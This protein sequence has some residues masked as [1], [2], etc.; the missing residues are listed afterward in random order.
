[1]PV[2]LS[3]E[4]SFGFGL[5]TEKGTYVDPTT[6]LPLVDVEANRGDTVE[7]KK[8]YVVL[9]MADGKEYQT[10]YYSA[11]EWA[12]GKLRSPVIPGSVSALFSWV[13]DRDAENQGKWA[14][15]LIDCVNEVKKITDAKIRRAT[16]DFA[17][18]EPVVCTLEVCGL[19]MDSGETPSPSIPVAAPYIFREAT[20]EIATG[21]GSLAEDVNC[22]AIRIEVDNVVEKA[23]EGLRLTEAGE[24]LELYNLAGVRCTGAFSRDFV[25]SGVYADFASGQ[26]AAT[27][28]TLERGASTATLSLPRVLHTGTDLGLPGSH[29]KRIVEEVDFVALGSTDG[30]TPPVVLA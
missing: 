2:A 10:S 4:G 15:V 25:D 22:E 16:F 12:E 5:Q 14:S 30:L 21:G 24:P 17:K 20:V 9:D 6:W 29:A 26:E 3:L 1:M 28:I 7:W 8:N 18:G 19:K 27:L 13:Q 23:E 11:G